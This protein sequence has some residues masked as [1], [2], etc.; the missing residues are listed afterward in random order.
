MSVNIFPNIIQGWADESVQL[1]SRS[2]SMDIAMN[3]EG[4]GMK[5][6]GYIYT[7]DNNILKGKCRIKMSMFSLM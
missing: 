2:S 5:V 6:L 7:T 3:K 1:F 4:N